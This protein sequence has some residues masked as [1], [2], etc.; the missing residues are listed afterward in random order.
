[1][2]EQLR[3]N[4]S[5]SSFDVLRWFIEL[6]RVVSFNTVDKI[7]KMLNFGQGTFVVDNDP[8]HP[9]PHPVDEFLTLEEGQG[10]ITIDRE[11]RTITHNRIQ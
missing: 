3:P 5:V 9:T 4:D 2:A 8:A 7:L 6:H 10:A 1:M 11:G